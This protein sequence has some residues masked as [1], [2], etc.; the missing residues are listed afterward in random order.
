MAIQC[1]FI[2]RILDTQNSSLIT[3]NNLSE[4]YFSEYKDQFNFIKDHIDNY[5]KV[6]DNM[7]FMAKFQDFDRFNVNE[8]DVYLVGELYKDYTKRALA[9][10]FNSVRASLVADNPDEALTK[11]IRASNEL[12]K[13]QQLSAVDIITSS[14]RYNTYTERTEGYNK[15]Y[16]KT[17]FPE[18]DSVIGGWDRNE[19]LVTIAARTNQGKSWLLLKS[20]VAAFQQGLRVGIYSGEMTENKVGYRLDTLMSG[21]SNYKITHGDISVSV[22]YKKFLDNLKAEHPEGGLLVLTPPMIGGPATVTALRAFIEKENLDILFVDQHSLLEDERKAKNPIERAANISRDLKNLQVM[23][24]IPIITVSQQNRTSTE[25]GV[26]TEH[27]AQS[28]RIA[29]DSTIIIFFE[30]KK[31]ADPDKRTSILTLN[32]VKSRDSVNNLKLTYEVNFD[33]GYFEYQPETGDALGTEGTD[34]M[35]EGVG[36]LPEENEEPVT[37][38]ENVYRS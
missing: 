18:L 22:E 13:T 19:E 28:D 8:P 6:P 14:T 20:A 27:I 11:I 36:L 38:H 30:Q 23:K 21:I 3:L 24:K 5:G 17:G 7:T 33:T 10:T 29:Q 35:K 32:L 31:S 25:N 2:N 12:V 1:Q 34:K 37:K 16:V 4:D 26:G 9:E 15:F